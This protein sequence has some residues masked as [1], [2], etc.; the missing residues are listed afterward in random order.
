M[1]VVMYNP[2]PILAEDVR[3]P[4]ICDADCSVFVESTCLKRS[5]PLFGSPP[6]EPVFVYSDLKPS[7]NPRLRVFNDE[8]SRQAPQGQNVL[9]TVIGTVLTRTETVA[10][11]VI[12][13]F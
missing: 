11:T 8:I 2:Q 1:E 7:Q 12:L 13:S 5:P 3:L 4:P 9:A 6:Y 10:K